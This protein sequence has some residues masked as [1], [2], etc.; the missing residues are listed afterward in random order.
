KIFSQFAYSIC[1]VT[2]GFR[3]ADRLYYSSS[4]FTLIIDDDGIPALKQM[5]TDQSDMGT[6]KEILPAATFNCEVRIDKLRT[7]KGWNYP[8][9]GG[10][11]CKKSIARQEGY[12]WCDSGER[13][14]EYPVMR[15]R[16]AWWDVQQTQFWRL[17]NMYVLRVEI[18]DSNAESSFVVDAQSKTVDGGS[19]LLPLTWNR[20][21]RFQD[22]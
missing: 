16:P 5:K 20:T 10:A 4:S 15:Q 14:V 8:S 12:F 11:K 3:L 21:R 7:K 2:I 9:C 18:E 6:S 17:R 1:R 19:L 13:V 22:C